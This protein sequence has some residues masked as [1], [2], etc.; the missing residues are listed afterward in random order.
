[1]WFAVG[2]KVY[3]KLVAIG[4]GATGKTSLYAKHS[5]LSYLYNAALADLPTSQT[6]L[7]V[8]VN[9]MFPVSE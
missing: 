9:G 1:M 3:R 6:R 7:N 5:K 2:A 4:D 8:Y